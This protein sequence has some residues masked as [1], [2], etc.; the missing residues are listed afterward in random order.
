MI[1]L[2]VCWNA[3]NKGIGD[4]GAIRIAEGLET[5]TSLAEL[6]IGRVY[7]AHSFLIHCCMSHTSPKPVFT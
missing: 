3:G 5:N 2:L 4:K 6:N 1:P 7:S